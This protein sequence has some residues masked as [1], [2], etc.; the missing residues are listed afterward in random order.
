MHVDPST[1][2]A[3]LGTAVSYLLSLAETPAV[4]HPDTSKTS[5]GRLCFFFFLENCILNKMYVDNHSLLCAGFVTGQV[6]EH[7]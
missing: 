3:P 2:A 1:P 7:R 5:V 4:S 6:S